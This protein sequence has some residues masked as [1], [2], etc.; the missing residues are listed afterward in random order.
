MLLLSPTPSVAEMV[1]STV[2][3]LVVCVLVPSTKLIEPAPLN[4]YPFAW[5]CRLLTLI[6]WVT[7]IVPTP[8]APKI[9]PSPLALF[10]APVDQFK[11]D[12]SQRRFAE[13]LFHVASAARSEEFMAPLSIIA[14][15]RVKTARRRKVRSDVRNCFMVS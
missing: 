4:E 8:V 10:Q 1:S 9:A 15:A 7:S 12:K 14:D 6:G 5:K 11:L 2:I 13:L 3:T